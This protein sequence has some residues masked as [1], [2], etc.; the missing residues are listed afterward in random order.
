MLARLL[1]DFSTNPDISQ[2]PG[3]GAIQTL[4]S[5][6]AGLSIA[7]CVMAWVAS[8]ALVAVGSFGEN[9]RA[10]ALGKRVVVAAALGSFLVGAAGAL[11][12]F[13]L[14]IGQIFN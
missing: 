4:I 6:L 7:F 2:G 12:H 5:Y 11:N 14:H 10:S 3:G 13:V 8:G 1:A 9:Y